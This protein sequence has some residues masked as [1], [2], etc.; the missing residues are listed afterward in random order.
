VR[1]GRNGT[2]MKGFTGILNEREIAAVT[3][4]VRN[5]FMQ[6][7][8]ENTRYH[9]VDNGWPNHERNRAASINAL[10]PHPYFF[11]TLRPASFTTEPLKSRE[12]TFHF[13]A[14]FLPPAFG[15]VKV[16]A[17]A[18]PSIFRLAH[19]QVTNILVTEVFPYDTVSIKGVTT[20]ERKGTFWGYHAGADVSVFVTR[21]VGVGI[22]V[23]YSHAKIKEFEQDAAATQGVA[24]GV[25][26]LAGVRFRFNSIQ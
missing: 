16:M 19:T 13:P 10:I 11:D 25:S 24:G 7:K 8:A 2:A 1:D 22:G 17:F 5:E 23:R 15:P 21:L 9:T 14:I 18:G 3:D 26:V 20:E 6:S 4:F 12:T